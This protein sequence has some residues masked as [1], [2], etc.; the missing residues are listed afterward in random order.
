M[1]TYP[2]PTF[3]STSKV[4]K[5]NKSKDTKI[6]L[7]MRKALVKAGLGHYKTNPKYVT[8]RPDICFPK[9]KVAIFT[10]GCWWHSCPYCNLPLPKSNR[11]FWKNKFIRNK[12]RDHRKK[13]ELSGKGWKVFEF[14]E[15]QVKDNPDRLALKIRGYINVSG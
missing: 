5:A 7:L 10:H 1:K 2:R 14:W 9:Y 3:K 12:E 6:E 4:M 11:L 15:H 13:L 8:G